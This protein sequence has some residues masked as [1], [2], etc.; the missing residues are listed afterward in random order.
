M[1]AVSVGA[2]QAEVNRD[3]EANEHVLEAPRHRQGND[4][5]DEEH[6]S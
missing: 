3:G 1:G 6:G 2:V 5:A 4:D